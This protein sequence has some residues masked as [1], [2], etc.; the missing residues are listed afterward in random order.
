MEPDVELSQAKSIRTLC[1]AVTEKL[2]VTFDDPWVT[3]PLVQP[4]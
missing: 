3:A 2:W 1:P 4:P